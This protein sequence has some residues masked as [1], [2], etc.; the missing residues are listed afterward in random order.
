MTSSDDAGQGRAWAWLEHLR[1]GGTTPWAQWAGTGERTGRV[2]PGAQQLELLRR[3]NEAGRPDPGLARRVL[4]A[5]APGRGR[6]DLEL[7]G[8]APQSRFGPAPVDPA[9]LPADELIRVTTSL[10]A[11]DLVAVPEP[12]PDLV[13][14]W[15]RLGGHWGRL[16]RPH[17]RLVG[18]PWRAD[19]ARRH[20]V[21]RGR[22]PGGASPTVLVLGGDLAGML[23]DLWTD[24]AF[25]TGGPVP[26]WRTWIDTVV[27]SGRLGRGADPLAS[28][29]RWT[30]RVGPRR[31]R[32]VLDPAALPGLVGV[33]SLPPA[34]S[35]SVDAIDLA[36]RIGGVLGLL[37]TPPRGREVLRQA[38]LPRL[39]DAPG[40]RLGV[41]PE[42]HRWVVRRSRRLRED[43]RSAGYPVVGTVLGSADAVLDHPRRL[44]TAQPGEPHEDRV[45]ALAVRMLLDAAPHQAPHQTPH[46]TQPQED[47]S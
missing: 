38:L 11:E 25:S 24:R 45:L 10:L 31:V 43:L 13:T 41:P 27:E 23:T 37:V 12:E 8:A 36:R 14:R 30:E 21:Q 6:P 29:R 34:P 3:L 20:L 18:D 2:L 22:P 17:Y 39:L 33:R 42:H 15:R 47:L 40:P 44:A 7:V 5:S 4:A 26:T 35:L 32:V 28:A 46:Q 1:E 16:R 9:D 19:A